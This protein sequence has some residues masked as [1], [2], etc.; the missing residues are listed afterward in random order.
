MLVGAGLASWACAGLGPRDDAAAPAC[1]ATWL[2][3]L[4]DVRT[5]AVNPKA[6]GLQRQHRPLNLLDRI[7]AL[8]T[9][10]FKYLGILGWTD[11]EAGAEV[12]GNVM[13]DPAWSTDGFTTVDV[14]IAKLDVVVGHARCTYARHAVVEPEAWIRIEIKPW[15]LFPPHVDLKAGD[16]VRI[17]GR[18]RVDHGAFYEI[19]PEGSA[20]I[21][22]TDH[23]PRPPPHA[24]R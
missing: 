14:A 18:L 1:G 16:A 13:H 10:P 20:D 12:W 23:P 4:V 22:R 21:E 8:L 15:V 19:H 2:G 24:S 6:L 7:S 3:A 9:T 17:R 11:L 5:C